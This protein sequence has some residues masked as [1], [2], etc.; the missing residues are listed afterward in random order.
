VQKIANQPVDL[1]RVFVMHPKGFE[2]ITGRILRAMI[3]I[4][5]D[6]QQG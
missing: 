6:G 2:I 5:R 3:G 4:T 1:V